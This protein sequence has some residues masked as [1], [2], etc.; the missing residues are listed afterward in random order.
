MYN[1]YERHAPPW[2]PE[3]FSVVTKSS[4][5]QRAFY[6]DWSTVN[7]CHIPYNMESYLIMKLTDQL[8]DSNA[9]VNK[10][11]TV[12]T[13]SSITANDLKPTISKPAGAV[14]ESHSIHKPLSSDAEHGRFVAKKYLWL[15]DSA[16]K[17][18]HEFS[19]TIEELSAL[20]KSKTCYYT[21]VE[22]V[23]YPHEKG[24]NADHLPDNYLTIDR[25]DNSR[26]YVNGNVV[27]CSKEI[28][29]L[30]DQMSESEFKQA[31]ALKTLLSQSNLNPDQ[32]HAFTAMMKGQS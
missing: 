26:G 17:R 12:N 13:R 25:K 3:T 7:P 15:M 20:L 23:S 19:I 22:L 1:Q 4:T 32:L 11:A 18:G 2:L 24:D 10:S 30:K 28:N 29:K 6:F 14:I 9:A 16:S 8:N 27:V 31:V 5:H 21:D